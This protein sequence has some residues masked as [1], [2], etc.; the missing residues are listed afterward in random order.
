MKVKKGKEKQT[1]IEE[2]DAPNG[3]VYDEKLNLYIADTRTDDGSEKGAR[4]KGLGLFAGDYGSDEIKELAIKRCNATIKDW[5]HYGVRDWGESGY[6][7][8]P[9]L[10]TAM[11]KQGYMPKISEK[12]NEHED[13]F[14]NLHDA[15][16]LAESVDI[17]FNFSEA[18]KIAGALGTSIGT[19]HEFMQ[20]DRSYAR[21]DIRLL[22]GDVWNFA[23]DNKDIFVYTRVGSMSQDPLQFFDRNGE[24]LEPIRITG[25]Q[26]KTIRNARMGKVIYGGWIAY[27]SKKAF[28]DSGVRVTEFDEHGIPTKM[29]HE[30]NTCKPPTRKDGSHDHGRMSDYEGHRWVVNPDK[31]IVAVHIIKDMYEMCLK[32]TPG[33]VKGLGLKGCVG[34]TTYL[35]TP[36]TKAHHA[37]IFGVANQDQ[38]NKMDR[39][40]EELVLL[41]NI[42]MKFK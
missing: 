7:A 18:L 23:S 16:K 8:I 29:D 4:I 37:N 9:I 1:D 30:E 32:E 38:I 36:I 22:L 15:L 34:P 25:V 27:E 40:L 13:T 39:V 5:W 19:H 33:W 41:S 42:D 17:S 11:V 28:L 10:A 26:A 14:M 35:T 12:P 6:S 24:P 20:Y 3:F 21:T 31:G 2:P